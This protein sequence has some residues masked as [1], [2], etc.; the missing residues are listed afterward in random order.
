M[1]TRQQKLRELYD[2]HK[3]KKGLYTRLADHC[4]V[5]PQ[6]V[7]NWFNRGDMAP[8]HIECVADFFGVSALSLSLKPEEYGRTEVVNISVRFTNH[9]PIIKIG[10]WVMDGEVVN[11]KREYTNA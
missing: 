6:A 2:S 4:G 7:Y 5:S 3:H 10:D 9:I 11:V 8:K 1:N